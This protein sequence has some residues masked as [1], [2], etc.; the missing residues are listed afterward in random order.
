MKAFVMKKIG[1]IGFMDKPV[2]APGPLDALIRPTKGLVCTSDIHTVH[3]AV[4]E[5][6][7]L[8][9]SELQRILQK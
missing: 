9:M 6:T 8:T 7:N 5:R 4:G 2:P 1:S 3:G